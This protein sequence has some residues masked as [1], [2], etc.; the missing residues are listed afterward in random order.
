[1]NFWNGSMRAG[2]TPLLVYS[3]MAP[4]SRNISMLTRC[5]LDAWLY[6]MQFSSSSLA[7]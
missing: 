5:C 6:F 4:G 1:M 2:S 3:V 7:M